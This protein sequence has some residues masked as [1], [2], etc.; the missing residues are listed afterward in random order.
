VAV[1]DPWGDALGDAIADTTTAGS[2]TPADAAAFDPWD[3]LPA[4]G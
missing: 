4:T 1:F 3:D 2:I